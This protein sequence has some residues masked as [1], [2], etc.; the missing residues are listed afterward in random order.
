MTRSPL[1]YSGGRLG[2]WNTMRCHY[3]EKKRFSG[4]STSSAIRA[5]ILKSIPFTCM[6][7]SCMSVLRCG[8]RGLRAF[9]SFIKTCSGKRDLH[10]FPSF[11]RL[12][13]GIRGL[14]AFH[15]FI[16]MC[17]GKRV[18]RAF[19]SFIKTCSGKRGLH[20]FPSLSDCS[21]VKGVFLHFPYFS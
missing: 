19:H 20:A 9:H 7:I 8:K 21:L 2:F 17:S 18:L 12:F 6:Y 13:S 10:A 1:S 11:I 4:S 16:I 5:L 15:S 14:P 3:T